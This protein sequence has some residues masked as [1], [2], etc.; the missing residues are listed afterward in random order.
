[1]GIINITLY[2]GRLTE[3]LSLL[4]FNKGLKSDY[5]IVSWHCPLAIDEGLDLSLD[6]DL[7][8]DFSML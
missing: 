4:V 6:A 8:F 2:M 1:M 5:W 7:D 3:S